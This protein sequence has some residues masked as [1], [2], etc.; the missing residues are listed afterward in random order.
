MLVIFEIHPQTTENQLENMSAVAIVP[1]DVTKKI[2]KRRKPVKSCAFCRHRKLKCDQKRPICS[3]CK[4]RNLSSCVYP[5]ADAQLQSDINDLS[6]GNVS[7]HDSTSP[8]AMDNAKLVMKVHSLERQIDEISRSSLNAN[9]NGA[10]STTSYHSNGS[11]LGTISQQA[12]RSPMSTTSTVSHSQQDVFQNFNEHLPNPLE[13]FYYLQCKA[14]GRRILYGATSMRTNLFKHRFG[15]G[16]K[17]DQLWTKV[18][19]ERN[20]WKQLHNTSTLLELKFVEKPNDKV[21]NTL[22][23]RLCF[24]LPPYN[25]CIETIHL[26]FDSTLKDLYLVNSILD[27]N[28]VIND[29]Y[30][31]FIPDSDNLMPNGDRKIKMLLAGNKK[32]YYKVG[33]IIQIITLRY[34]YQNCPESVDLFCLYLLGQFSA[35][36]FF[37]ERLQFLLLRCYYLKTYRSDCDDSNIINIVTNMV[38]TAIS[39]G[40]DRNID[41]VYKD[42]ENIVGSLRSLKNMWMVIVF[43]DLECA[44]QTG[45]PLNLASI[46]LDFQSDDEPFDGEVQLN[47]LRKV[48]K[49][50]RKIL[51]CIYTK[52]GTPKFKGLVDYII[53]FMERELPNISY[54]MDSKLLAEVGL[55]DV[56]IVTFCLEMIL[57]LNNLN[58]AINRDVG[59]SLRNSSIHTSLLAFHVLNAV[60]ERC[61]QLDKEYFPE[62]FDRTS[63]TLTPYFVQSIGLT[64]G[65]LPRVSSIFCAIVYYRLTIFINNDFLFYN[66]TPFTWNSKTLRACEEEIAVLF[67]LDIHQKL[68]DSWLRPKDP[69]KRKIMENSYHFVVANAMQVTFRKVLDKCL[70]YRKRAEDAWV[71][72][73][74]DEL[75]LD[76]GSYPVDA[77]SK[78]FEILLQQEMARKKS[79]GK[80]LCPISMITN[81][82]KLTAKE[83]EKDLSINYAMYELHA[84]KHHPPKKGAGENNKTD[85][86]SIGTFTPPPAVVAGSPVSVDDAGPVSDVKKTAEE[87]EAEMLQQITD[88]FWSN[89]NTGWEELL[90]HTDAH[91]LFNNCL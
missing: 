41:Q 69:T 72:Q 29:F 83:I 68:C 7:V 74:G 84:S 44:I 89:Y 22:L 14:S 60:T 46:D 30:T 12:T 6:N 61:F 79:L 25:K 28:K 24:E 18:K 20:K 42:Q 36:V 16:E 21:F 64:A 58:F 66:Q 31:C 67:A 59:S 35:K 8:L 86:V 11:P 90:N 34:F 85:I 56:R 1:D 9:F 53:D 76:I 88:E 87:K 91:D 17:Y 82:H 71:S 38:S 45:R 65:L 55:D 26:F 75:K 80:G 32:N 15:F 77:T 40:L 2:R 3:S 33:V 43:L 54:F 52:R 47:K 48:T 57:C 23:Q 10:N 39:M 13:E 27:K 49:L 78:D 81:S 4:S 51:T 63:T 37:I 62:M 70:E 50:G 73:L 19:F 5:V